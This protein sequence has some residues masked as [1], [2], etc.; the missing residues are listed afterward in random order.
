MISAVPVLLFL[1]KMNLDVVYQ[2]KCNLNSSSK[3][4]CSQRILV[5]SHANVYIDF[6]LVLLNFFIVFAPKCLT[7][8]VCDGDK[9]RLPT[10]YVMN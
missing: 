3:C 8:S 1:H 6:A 4:F 9:G 10:F 2:T 5:E 7:A